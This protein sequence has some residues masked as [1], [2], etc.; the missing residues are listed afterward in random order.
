MTARYQGARSPARTRTRP[1]P[2]LPRVPGRSARTKRTRCAKCRRVVHFELATTKPLKLDAQRAL[3]IRCAYCM[4]VF[5]KRCALPHFE[6][7]NDARLAARVAAHLLRE[8]R[9]TPAFRAMAKL[10]GALTA[11]PRAR[12]PR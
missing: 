3:A 6:R 12:R 10:L 2:A 11:P 9:A 5:C 7:E 4:Q 8:L 1:T